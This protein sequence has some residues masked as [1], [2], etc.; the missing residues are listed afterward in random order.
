M[1]KDFWISYPNVMNH[2]Q[3]EKKLSLKFW[4]ALGMG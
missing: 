2:N 4:S 3:L 1:I